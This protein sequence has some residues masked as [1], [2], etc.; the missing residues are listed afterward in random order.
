METEQAKQLSLE[1]MRSV[2][3]WG[4]AT[5]DSN[6]FPQV[7][8]MENLRS[9]EKHPELTE[10]FDQHSDDFLIY[11]ASS[12][13][14]AKI[15][16]IKANPKASAYFC[17]AEQIHSLMLV[18]TAEIVTDRELGRKL[19]NSEWEVIWPDGAD[20]PDYTVIKLQPEFARGWY[21]EGPFEFKLK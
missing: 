7:R 3:V 15:E 11:V 5:I 17:N 13:Q 14:T 12:L 6:G 20:D 8:A 2:P 16:Q 9:T 18:G 10:I 21:K 4:F 1:L 19:W